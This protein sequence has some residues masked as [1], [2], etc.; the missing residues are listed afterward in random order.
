M[1]GSI[2]C[3]IVPQDDYATAKAVEYEWQGNTDAMQ[4]AEWEAM[5]KVIGTDMAEYANYPYDDKLIALCDEDGLEKN[6]GKPINRIYAGT[7]IVLG[8]APK[9][10]H[11]MLTRD[12]AMKVVATLNA[13]MK[14][15][16]VLDG[17]RRMEKGD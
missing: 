7:W 4:L 12:E 15:R 6:E 10:V 11:R 13:G 1:K 14:P 8:R 16:K 5:K 9:T 2:Y 3:V 17:N